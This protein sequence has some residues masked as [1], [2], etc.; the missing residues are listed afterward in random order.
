MILSSPPALTAAAKWAIGIVA[1]I[2]AVFA[3]L[4]YLGLRRAART[5]A[6]ARA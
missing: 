1:D 5:T 2:V 4:Q 6:E 3:L